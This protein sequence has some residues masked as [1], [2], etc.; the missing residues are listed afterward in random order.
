MI[1]KNLSR[2]REDD[3]RWGMMR[4]E[5]GTK[6]KSKHEEYRRGRKVESN[7]KGRVENNRESGKELTEDEN[8]KVRR[9]GGRE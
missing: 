7:K 9:R 6:I 3:E 1:I 4:R 5:E 2:G 8:E